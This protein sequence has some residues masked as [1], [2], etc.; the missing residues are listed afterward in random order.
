MIAWRGTT[1]T[2]I[3]KV[4]VVQKRAI[5]SL[6]GLEPLALCPEAFKDHGIMTVVGL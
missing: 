4:F 6:K 1:V 3:Q 5:R 2:N